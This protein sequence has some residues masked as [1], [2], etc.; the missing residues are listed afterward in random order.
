[1]KILIF[2]CGMKYEL[3]TPYYKP[4]GGSETSMLL[5]AKGL[6]E[7]DQSVVLLTSSNTNRE[8]VR[9]L[10]RDNINYF[11]PYAEQSDVIICSRIIPPEIMNFI[12]KKKI[13]YFSHD[14]YDQNHVKWMM[15]QN[16]IN[17]IDKIFCVSN[18]QKNT[19][20]KYLNVNESKMEV[21]GNPID[22]SLY[23]GFT[24]RDD[25]TFI[26][27]SI[28]YK[29]DN[30]GK[31]FNDIC[32]ISHKQNLKLKVF[33]SFK[34]YD[35]EKQDQ[36]YHQFFKELTNIKGIEINNLVS[37]R[38]LAFEFAKST[39]SLFPNTYHETFSMSCLQSQA[40]GCIPISTNLGAMNERIENGY[41]GFI[42]KGHNIQNQDTYQ[43][44]L[45]L[46]IKILSMS[47][48]ELYKIRLN[49]QESIKQFDYLK[50]SS[51]ILQFF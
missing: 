22:S 32:L 47:E 27:A 34:L 1:M 29:G 38:E 8:H 12:G 51:K 19:F 36:E 30:I 24:E 16:S 13:F 4:L 43:E 21:I 48:N 49:C 17:F 25:K 5:L 33:S 50:I 39:F 45:D 42:T 6:S 7:L 3:D 14:A 37:M 2:D 35:N 18:W 28:P 15:N 23:N 46:T 11:I 20:N 9:N 44:F 26:F 31:L 40:S 10:I 41:N